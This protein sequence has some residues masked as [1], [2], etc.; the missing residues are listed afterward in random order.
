MGDRHNTNL[1]N[2]MKNRLHKGEVIDGRGR[3][4][5]RS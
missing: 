5:E 2:I 1:S 3:V 4:K